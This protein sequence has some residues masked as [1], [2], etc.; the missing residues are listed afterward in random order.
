[1]SVPIVTYLPQDHV[2]DAAQ[3]GDMMT[4]KTD[5]CQEPL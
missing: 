2:F 5:T 3:T 4:N 1:M